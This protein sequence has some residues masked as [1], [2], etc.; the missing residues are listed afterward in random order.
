MHFP[1]LCIKDR[2]RWKTAFEDPLGHFEYLIMPFSLAN[3]PAI[4]QAL[5]N[6]VLR[7]FINH[8]VFVYLYNT[9]IFSQN[10]QEHHS[11][12]QQVLQRL[13]EN[14]LFV[15]A[16]KFEFHVHSISFLEFIVE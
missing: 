7:D 16:E 3:A 2:D 8:F 15:K 10:Q 14:K 6:D 12:I 4:F 9:L 1:F 5:V 13:L 11:H